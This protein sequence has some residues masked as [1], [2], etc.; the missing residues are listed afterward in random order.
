MLSQLLTLREREKE[1]RVRRLSRPERLQDEEIVDMSTWKHLIEKCR[2]VIIDCSM[3]SYIDTN[4]VGR[5]KRLS[6]DIHSVGMELFLASCAPHVIDM[7]TRCHFFTEIEKNRTFITVHDAFLVASDQ[8]EKKAILS[9]RDA[10][11]RVAGSEIVHQRNG[12]GITADTIGQ[13]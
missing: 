6:Q 2:I 4:G 5:L 7:L 3:L 8:L 12:L 13:L 1:R 11:N 9:I 10:E